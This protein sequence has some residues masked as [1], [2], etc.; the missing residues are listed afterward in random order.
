MDKKDKLNIDEILVLKWRGLSSQKISK[1]GLKEFDK[2]YEEDPDEFDRLIDKANSIFDKQ[3]SL[4]I[5]TISIQDEDYP[6]KLKNIGN[7][8]PVLIHMLGNVD[9][10]KREKA[11]AIIGARAAD[12]Q[13]MDAAYNLGKKYSEEGNVIVSGLALGCDKAGHEG[14]L[15]A[16]GE[17]IA[18][19][20]SGLDM[21]H[22]KENEDLQKRILENG[23]L[24]LSEQIIK[25]KASPSTLVARNRLQAAL[26]DSVVL[27]QCPEQSG[28]MHTMRFA[29][30]YHKKSVAVKFPKKT[31]LNAG[32]FYLIENNLAEPLSD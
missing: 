15:A 16:G 7:E 3:E 13:G 2:L 21:V 28:S 12:K 32:N 25:T 1:I 20:G 29:R 11:V 8:A 31:N 4:G 27:A 24:I 30:H 19:V 26:S 17:T 10:L 5:K 6:D 9:L 23:G 18:I 14:C 22:P